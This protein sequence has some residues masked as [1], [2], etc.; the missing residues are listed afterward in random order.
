[1]KQKITITALKDMKHQGK[2]ITGV[3]EKGSQDELIAQLQSKGLL[4]MSVQ[5]HEETAR[6]K[7]KEGPAK[8]GRKRMHSR[9]TT[10]DLTLFCRQLGTLLGA[11]VTILES[12]KIIQQQIASRKFHVVLNELREDMEGGLS[13]HEAMAKKPKIFSY[14]KYTL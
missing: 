14:P 5:L 10:N 2:K 6:A 1:M 8:I 9:I 12:L 4:V 13:F 3:Q 11:G 7:R